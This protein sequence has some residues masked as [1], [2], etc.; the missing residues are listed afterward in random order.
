M[1][2][3]MLALQQTGRAEAYSCEAYLYKVRYD[4]KLLDL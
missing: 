3:P 2:R 1:G 4:C